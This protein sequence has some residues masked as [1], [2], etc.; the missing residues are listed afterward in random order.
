[1]KLFQSNH[2]MGLDISKVDKVYY[3]YVCDK[4]VFFHPDLVSDYGMVDFPIKNC[5]IFV[6]NLKAVLVYPGDK[7]LHYFKHF[8]RFKTGEIVIDDISG[9]Y[10]TYFLSK[11]YEQALIVSP[12]YGTTNISWYNDDG[13]FITTINNV[14]GEIKTVGIE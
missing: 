9:A 10:S 1:M 13:R 6:M 5:D 2:F 4:A 14:T 11:K 12:Q 7:I 8:N 3:T